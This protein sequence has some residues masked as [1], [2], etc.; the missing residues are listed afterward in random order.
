[1]IWKP[2]GVTSRRAVEMAQRLLGERPLG[3]TGTLDPLAS[4]ILIVL[5]GEARKFQNI[6]TDHSKCYEA[7]IVF[8]IESG[9]EDAEGPLWCPL[10]RGAMPSR[11][12]ID[13]ALGGFVGEQEQVPPRLSAVR[14]DGERSH[15]RARRGEEVE[16]PPRRVR[17]DAIEVLQWTAPL[18]T[19]RVACGAGTYIRSFARDLG[20]QLG[21][22]AFLV[23]L[24]RTQVGSF[25]EEEAVPL[26]LL[27][28]DSWRTTEELVRDIP[29]LDVDKDE[30]YALSLGQQLPARERI[31][32]PTVVWCEER[33]VGIVEP[34]EELW[35]PRR[36]LR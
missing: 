10:P 5:G 14:V 7:R 34:R 16:L 12:A 17:I 25:R 23:G 4:G 26:T 15:K 33:V 36:W 3:H 28:A 30:A 24:R 11:E 18:L 13:A 21:V 27:T 29:R 20:E 6:V 19:L 35:Q 22:G 9:S 2:S 31:D 8:G 32:G 1:M